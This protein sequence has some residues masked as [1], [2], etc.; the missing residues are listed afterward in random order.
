MA[1]FAAL[2]AMNLGCRPR[3]DYVNT[4]QNPSGCLSRG[5]WDDIVVVKKLKSGEWTARDLGEVPW[6][7]ILNLDFASSAEF[8]TA[9]GDSGG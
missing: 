3:I 4:K 2:H 5:G 6:Q 1:L 8:V 7:T 9:L